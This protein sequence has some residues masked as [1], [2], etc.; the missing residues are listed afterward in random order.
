MIFDTGPTGTATRYNEPIHAAVST[1]HTPAE[2]AE[3]NEQIVY[4]PS[5]HRVDEQPA[6]EL[7][8]AKAN[9]MDRPWAKSSW[10]YDIRMVGAWWAQSWARA[11]RSCDRIHSGGH[12][13]PALA[14]VPA[15]RSSAACRPQ[16]VQY[17]C[18][19]KAGLSRHEAHHHCIRWEDVQR[20]S[21]RDESGACLLPN[22]H[23]TD[24]RLSVPQTLSRSAVDQIAIGRSLGR[25]DGR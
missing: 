20:R 11:A 4:Q 7:S 8:W 2:T 14:Y 9:N 1:L 21:G 17:L 23:P 13:P 6:R 15:K 12:T 22:R 19:R 16:T 3:H 10:R 24:V 25:D 18:T 5:S